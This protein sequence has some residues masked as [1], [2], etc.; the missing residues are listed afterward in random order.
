MS[1]EAGIE[2]GLV[3]LG[4]G[5]T[6]AAVGIETRGGTFTALIGIGTAVPCHRT[7]TFTTADSGQLSLKVKVYAGTGAT[8]ADALPLGAYELMLNES[9]GPGV[10]Q[11]SVTFEVGADGRFRISALDGGGRAV[12]I[13]PDAG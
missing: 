10:P 7:E 9:S 8:V 6:A 2:G 13:V 11:L 12:W 3:P 5:K 4:G 1:S